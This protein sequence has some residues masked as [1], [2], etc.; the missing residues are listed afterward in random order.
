VKQHDAILLGAI[1]DPRLE[2]GLPE[3][4]IIAK[5]RLSSTCS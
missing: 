4:G 3:F 2:V 5:M 1:G